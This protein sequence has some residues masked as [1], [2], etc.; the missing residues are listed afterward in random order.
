MRIISDILK[1]LEFELQEN[2]NEYV[3]ETEIYEFIIENCGYDKIADSLEFFYIRLSA[4]AI[5]AELISQEEHGIPCFDE[6]YII[7]ILNDRDEHEYHKLFEYY[8]GKQ[9][10]LEY[11]TINKKTF[12]FGENLKLEYNLLLKTFSMLITA[13]LNLALEKLKRHLMENVNLESWCDLLLG[14]HEND[15]SPLEKERIEELV[16]VILN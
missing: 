10:Y 9:K 7:E 13:D 14:G 3:S 4:S 2:E 6:D 5:S 16:K 15:Y 1:D 8:F 12:F 11:H